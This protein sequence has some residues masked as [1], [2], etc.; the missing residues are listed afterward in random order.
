MPVQEAVSVKCVCYRWYYYH[1]LQLVERGA[2][3]ILVLV[4]RNSNEKFILE[5]IRRMYMNKI[6][7]PSN[8]RHNNKNERNK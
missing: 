6:L 7:R 3:D 4:G 1:L 2:Q 8:S 5:E